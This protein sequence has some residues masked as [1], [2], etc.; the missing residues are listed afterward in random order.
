MFNANTDA[1]GTESTNLTTT[2]L[3]ANGGTI[4]VPGVFTLASGTATINSP[5]TLTGT[6][7]WVEA[8]CRVQD[9]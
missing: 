4:S 9:R 3:N 8:R 6:G 1:S 7:T 5:M 2:T